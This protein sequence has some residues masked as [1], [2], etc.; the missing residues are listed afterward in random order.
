M[1]SGQDDKSWLL[2]RALDVPGTHSFC[3]WIHL[4]LLVVSQLLRDDS[5]TAVTQ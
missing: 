2:L 5:N 4:Q 3:I 1:S